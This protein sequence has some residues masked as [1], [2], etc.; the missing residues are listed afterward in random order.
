MFQYLISVLSQFFSKFGD[1][2]FLV[3]K[4]LNKSRLT[5]MITNLSANYTEHF[6]SI[7]TL[8]AELRAVSD[9]EIRDR[10]QDLKI[11]EILNAEKSNPH[12]FDLAK[13]S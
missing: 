4:G 9:T 8:E 3:V 12:F 5:E 11:F 6:E 13:K 7:K 2:I 1:I 10:L